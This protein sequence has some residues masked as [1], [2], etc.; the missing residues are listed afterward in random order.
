MY[1]YCFPSVGKWYPL[2]FYIPKLSKSLKPEA[3]LLVVLQNELN[4]DDARFT[5]Y[6]QT[7]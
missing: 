4:S 5:T 3:C 1:S 6:V 7:C 2:I